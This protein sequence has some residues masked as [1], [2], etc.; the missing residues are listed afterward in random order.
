V[1]VLFPLLVLAG[2]IV[3]AF[4]VATKIAQEDSDEGNQVSGLSGLTQ[5]EMDDLLNSLDPSCSVVKKD[6]KLSAKDIDKLTNLLQ[7]V[8]KLRRGIG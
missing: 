8:S 4:K 1:K 3:L 2:L 5:N 7:N 6:E